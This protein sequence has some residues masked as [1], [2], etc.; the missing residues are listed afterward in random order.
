MSQK[1]RRRN[2]DI[3]KQKKGKDFLANE[4]SDFDTNDF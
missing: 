3:P 1:D 2:I 4:N